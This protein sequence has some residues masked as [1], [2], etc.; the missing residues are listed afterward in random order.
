MNHQNQRPMMAPVP[1]CDPSEAVIQKCVMCESELFNK[2]FKI[3]IVSAVAPRNRT[4]QELLAET[5]FFYCHKC[6]HR[7]GDPKPVSQ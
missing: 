6:G 7:Y 5:H 2:I 4:G 3:G 1:A